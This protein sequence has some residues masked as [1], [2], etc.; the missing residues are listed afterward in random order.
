MTRPP[1]HTA[2]LAL[3]LAACLP[4]HPGIP[5]L[6][7]PTHDF[8]GDGFTERQGDCDDAEA[9]T[10]PNAVEV[11]DAVDADCDGQLD[12]EDAEGKFSWHLDEDGDTYGVLLAV[13]SC[14]APTEQYV[15]QTGDCDDSDKEVHPGAT[16]VWYDGTDQDC[17]R[18]DT[19]RDGD[20][21]DF[22]GSGG[23]DC[24]D[25]DPD[26]HPQAVEVWY[27]GV[28]EN[29]DGRNDFDQDGDG[30]LDSEGGGADCDDTNPAIFPGAF[31]I[32]YDGIDQ[33]CDGKSDY[34][35]DDDGW[36][37]LGHGGTDCEDGDP[38]IH[39]AAAEIWYDGTDQ[40]CAGDDDFD[41]DADA[42]P[43]APFG[44]DC[45]DTDP[46][47]HPGAPEVWY[48]GTN[49]A[50]I[51]RSDFDQ[52][53]DGQD[54]E[55][56][57]DD[58]DDLDQHTYDGAPEV[59]YDG[60]DQACDGGDDFDQDGD[61]HAIPP[62][63]ADCLD[64]N[65]DVSPDTTWFRDADE[66]G[67]GDRDTTLD[68]CTP[69]VGYVLN[70]D[71]CDDTN[72]AIKSCTVPT[73]LLP[74]P[75]LYGPHPGN[76]GPISAPAFGML[77]GAAL[78]DLAVGIPASSSHQGEAYVRPL[79]AAGTSLDDGPTYTAPGLYELGQAVAVG[80]FDATAGDDLLI[81]GPAVVGGGEV[82]L[83]SGPIEGTGGQVGNEADVV[84]VSTASTALGNGLRGTGD[85][86]DDGISD[87]IVSDFRWPVTRDRGLV[88]F[89]GSDEWLAEPTPVGLQLMPAFAGRDDDALG[90]AIDAG[91]DFTGDG[92]PDILLGAPT[93]GGVTTDNGDGRVHVVAG[94]RVFGALALAE[95]VGQTWSATGD[96]LGTSVAFAGDIDG[97]GL[98]DALVG[99]RCRGT[100]PDREGVAYL[101]LGQPL[102][103]GHIG[104]ISTAE[105]EFVGATGSRTGSAVEGPGDVNGDGRPDVLIG[106]SAGGALQQGQVLLY[107]GPLTGPQLD[108]HATRIIEGVEQ[109]GAFGSAITAI[110]DL[111]GDLLSDFAVTADLVDGSLAD[112]GSVLIVHGG[113]L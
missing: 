45:D 32:W 47:A 53:A 107:P 98:S 75:E 5:H 106:A 6:D 54:R 2:W 102:V 30:E 79:A 68:Q 78:P 85:L 33:N 3:A 16:E 63:G 49:Q 73:A 66:D 101:I 7:D 50:C 96:C 25:G 72:A 52:D 94:E 100:G 81:S 44:Y 23:D 60:I 112:Q 90:Y 103:A 80:P 37:A 67:E 31:E 24:N 1:T 39:P 15:L 88:T 113:A 21:A 74:G 56:E 69:P 48:D 57:G 38:N 91:Q 22:D 17:D 41:Q 111:D 76:D 84:F 65:P 86:D 51:T 110:G 29:C 12:D 109:D 99:G 89:V 62:A 92:L 34:D 28:D 77:T 36:D 14:I 82:Y 4:P 43:I 40:D 46:H 87:F 108:A 104:D 59:W 35:R 11:C 105:A 13:V 19:D 70:P 64:T 27:N 8:D 95:L 71:D 9:T 97:D 18:N 83:L 26:I 58:C 20:G 93:I 42:H 55:P 61:G 10:N